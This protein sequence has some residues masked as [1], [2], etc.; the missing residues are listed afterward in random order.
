MKTYDIY[1]DD[2]RKQGQVVAMDETDAVK[3]YLGTAY[4]PW[5]AAY[6]IAVLNV[7]RTITG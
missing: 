7:F 4:D 5:S 6:L 3:R 1:T 2:W